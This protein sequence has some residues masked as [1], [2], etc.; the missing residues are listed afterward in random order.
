MNEKEVRSGPEQHL[1]T[2][3]IDISNGVSL[4]M[5]RIIIGKYYVEIC[6]SVN[7]YKQTICN[8]CLNGFYE[9]IYKLIEPHLVV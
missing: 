7:V 2:K 4:A 8:Q 3:K 6:K 9:Y 1:Y 5:H